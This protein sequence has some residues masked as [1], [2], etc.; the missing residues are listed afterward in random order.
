MKLNIFIEDIYF[1]KT[2]IFSIRKYFQSGKVDDLI[3][4]MQKISFWEALRA[5][6]SNDADAV[7]LQRAHCDVPF[8]LLYKP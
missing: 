7:Q 1:S 5:E 8:I 4:S 6:K 2:H 3:C